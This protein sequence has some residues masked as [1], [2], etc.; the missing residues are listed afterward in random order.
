MKKKTLFV[1][2]AAFIAAFY[3]V[4]GVLSRTLGLDSGAVQLRLS[5]ALCVLPAIMPSA[6]W[7]VSI[8]CLIFN[9]LFTGSTLDII[10]GTLATFIGAILASLFKKNKYLAFI[11]T[12]ISNALV[13]PLVICF[14]AMDGNLSA[15]PFLTISIA[16]GELA[17]CGGIGNLLLKAIG[18]RKIL[19]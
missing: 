8:G 5:E 9:I 7:G 16:I 18:N 15:L 10:F 17:A 4:L 19:F 1:T 11:P 13:I 3:V 14:T 6:I 2:Y 12:V